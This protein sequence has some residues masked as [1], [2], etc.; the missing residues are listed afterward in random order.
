MRTI[1]LN[2]LFSLLCLITCSLGFANNKP[3]PVDDAYKISAMV[4]DPQTII[5]KWQIAPGYYLYRDRF[6]FRAG[7]PKH[8]RLGQPLLPT[9]ITK[10]NDL[11]GTYQAYKDEAQIGVP[12]IHQKDGKISLD[13][14]YQGCSEHGFC[15]PPTEKVFSLNLKG[16]YMQATQPIAIDTPTA[17]TS[18]AAPPQDRIS[19]LL[20][21]QNYFTMML[22]FLGFGLLIAFTPCVL[23]MVPIVSGIVVGQG[24]K[25][26][27]FKGFLLS[28]AYVQGMA[29][30]YAIAGVLFGTIGSN[31]QTAL[32]TPL[33]ITLFSLLFVA[34][35]LSLF[36][37][38]EVKVPNF[39]HHHAHKLSNKQK[40]GSFLGA[41]FMGVL[42]T[43]ILSPCV[44]APLV[45]TLGFI[46]STGNALLGGV[47]L[48]CMGLGMGIPLL[49]IG[50]LEGRFL[51]K[52][53]TWMHT[54]KN[55]LGVLMLGVAIWM[56]ARVLPGPATLAL[57]GI[58]CISS[59]VFMGTLSG[60][61][62]KTWRT[63]SKLTAGWVLLIYGSALLFGAAGGG[64]DPLKPLAFLQG[65]QQQASHHPVF[66]RI[67]SKA[68]LEQYLS[69]AKL[70]NKPI[71]L[72]FY[73]DWCVSCKEMEK[74][75]FAN[76]KVSELMQNFILLQV[77]VTNNTSLDKQLQSSCNVV[78][79]PT[80][81]FFDTKGKEMKSFR[82]I[83]EMNADKFASHLQQVLQ[84]N[85]P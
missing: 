79:P 64:S 69:N 42:S 43:L 7:N 34:M 18:A 52:T 12:V 16:P 66:K 25:N 48:Y 57:W 32:Q 30:T 37:V 39:L 11:L 78:A 38:Y 19:K 17:M 45:G 56:L 68:E 23:P 46:S 28:L 54:V 63:Y 83:G 33:V 74:F 61:P 22:S 60:H 40:S 41:F 24:D 14:S 47:A 6:H 59:A 10:H 58:L 26:H 27:K 50:G 36:G 73:A 53:G 44:T 13:V 35:A 51:P 75:T 1:I 62:E 81:I 21:K 72:D 77:D 55:I 85:K 49:I 31:I 71:M 8:T 9:G 29:I 80:I 76:P 3:L 5:V 4:K 82:V 65:T 20:S 70:H 15:Y 2:T 84:A 67:K